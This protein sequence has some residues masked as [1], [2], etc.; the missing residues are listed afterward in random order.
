MYDDSVH[1]GLTTVSQFVPSIFLSVGT[2]SPEPCGRHSVPRPQ[3]PTLSPP[4]PFPAVS[5]PVVVYSVRANIDKLGERLLSS[6]S[7]CVARGYSAVLRYSLA[8]YSVRAQT[9][10]NELLVLQVGDILTLF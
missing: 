7:L 8:I 3:S 5:L 10:M 6:A 1:S 9:F 4:P 2:Q